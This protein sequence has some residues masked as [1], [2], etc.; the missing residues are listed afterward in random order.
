[1]IVRFLTMKFN[2]E[3]EHAGRICYTSMLLATVVLLGE[4]HVTFIIRL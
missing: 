3:T 1:M 4:L 2:G